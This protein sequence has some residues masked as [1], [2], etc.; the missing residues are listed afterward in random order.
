VFKKFQRKIEDFKCENCGEFVKGDG[1][2]NH[3][4]ECLYS[5][6]VDNNPGDRANECGGLMKPIDAFFKKQEWLLRQECQKCGEIMTIR[7]RDEDNKKT[8]EKVIENKISNI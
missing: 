1:Y 3:C 6:H 4:P 7:V 2:T 5:K 8:L